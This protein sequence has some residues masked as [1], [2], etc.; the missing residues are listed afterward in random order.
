[1]AVWTFRVLSEDNKKRQFSNFLI[2][3]HSYLRIRTDNDD[4]EM[5]NRLMLSSE[6]VLDLRCMEA[7]R[8]EMI[9][10]ISTPHY[11]LV[12]ATVEINVTMNATQASN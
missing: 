9:T 7:Q 1:M 5:A 3:P 2:E 12:E 4:S 8:R 11:A 6:I 10:L